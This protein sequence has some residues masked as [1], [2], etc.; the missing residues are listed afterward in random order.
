MCLYYFVI[1]C[2]KKPGKQSEKIQIVPQIIQKNS[3]C[4]WEAP[5]YLKKLIEG[6][7]SFIISIFFK[8]KK[9]SKTRARRVI[10]FTHNNRR[11][12][13]KERTDVFYYQIMGLLYSKSVTRREK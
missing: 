8:I 6:P 2:K 1:T 9:M 12:N 10:L 11:I 13:Y 4:F 3:D 7:G 5:F